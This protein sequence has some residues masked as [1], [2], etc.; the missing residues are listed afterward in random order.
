MYRQPA[1]LCWAPGSA[2]N[3]GVTSLSPLVQKRGCLVKPVMLPALGLSFQFV[4]V[5][6]I[7]VFNS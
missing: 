2:A 7:Y 5:L 4:P 3:R 6:Y 1:E